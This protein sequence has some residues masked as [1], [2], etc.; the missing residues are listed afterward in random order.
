MYDFVKTNILSQTNPVVPPH[1]LWYDGVRDKE[2]KQN[3][4]DERP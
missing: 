3:R 4:K 2:K 1:P